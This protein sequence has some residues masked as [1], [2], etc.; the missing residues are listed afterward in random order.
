MFYQKFYYMNR[1]IKHLFFFFFLISCFY[2]IIYFL[3]KKVDLF[4]NLFQDLKNVSKICTEFVL[5]MVSP[6]FVF[7]QSFLKAKP[8]FASL[9]IS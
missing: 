3:L 4:D 9:V 8:Q 5:R 1:H 2:F 6:S 7:I